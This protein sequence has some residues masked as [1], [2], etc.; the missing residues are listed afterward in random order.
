M[1]FIKAAR[2]MQ[3]PQVR[4]LPRMI[5]LEPTLEDLTTFQRQH[6]DPLANTGAPLSVDVETPANRL[7]CI[8]LAT[9]ERAAIVLPLVDRRKPGCNYWP[10]LQDEL[11]AIAWLRGILQDA[12]IKKVMQNGL[13]DVQ[14]LF[15]ELRIRV[16]G[17]SEDTMLAHHALYS[18]LQKGLDF[19]GSVYTDEIAWKLL[20]PRGET[21]EMKRDE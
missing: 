17:F 18:E 1:D 13:F 2:E 3:F 6:I 14:R 19:L 9:S 5:W 12:R 15:V 10:S 4:R 8:G 11:R 7:A 21:T 16:L 20:R